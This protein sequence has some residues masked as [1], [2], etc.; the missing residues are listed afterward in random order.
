MQA[1][2]PIKWDRA[3]DVLSLGE[4][5]LKALAACRTEAVK[6]NESSVVTLL[7]RLNENSG[8]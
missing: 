4:T 3:L 1:A 5:N 6:T 2:N 7:Y 8:P